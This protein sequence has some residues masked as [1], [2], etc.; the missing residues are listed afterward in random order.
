MW[1]VVGDGCLQVFFCFAD[2]IVLLAPCASALRK[3]LLLCSA[4]ATSHGLIF[5]T[6]KTQLICFRKYAHPVP[7]AII[8]F[9]GVH[10]NF[11]NTVLHPGHL[12]TF[13]LNDQEDIVRVAKDINLKANS[14]MCTFGFSDHF[15]LTYL[16]KSYC[17]SLY[18]CVLWSLSS[19]ALK[20]LQVAINK[21]LYTKN[22]APPLEFVNCLEDCQNLLFA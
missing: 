21:I 22:L 17:L 5:N 2:D 12:V 8:E 7:A 16:F 10:L 19:H 9:N 3:M 4:Y 20:H 1:V 13:D 18:G 15:V 14:M 11:S 6:E